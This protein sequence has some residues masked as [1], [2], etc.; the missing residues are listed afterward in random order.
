MLVILVHVFTWWHMNALMK[1]STSH[2]RHSLLPLI[3]SFRRLQIC[4]PELPPCGHGDLI[5]KVN[6]EKISKERVKQKVELEWG[7]CGNSF[8]NKTMVIL[9]EMSGVKRLILWD[10]VTKWYR[11]PTKGVW[12]TCLHLGLICPTLPL[13]HC[14]LPSQSCPFPWCTTTL[15]RIDSTV[16]IVTRDEV[17]QVILGLWPA[18]S[19]N[20]GGPLLLCIC[21]VW[22][23]A[24]VWM[25]LSPPTRGQRTELLSVS[26]G[27]THSSFKHIQI[28]RLCWLKGTF[29]SVWD[30]N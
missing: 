17:L 16:P 1:C 27:H 22:K 5:L 11:I 15:K 30:E 8:G 9:K 26:Y 13:C 10:R 18:S 4:Y 2:G 24:E 29:L 28:N 21:K 12:T 20:G 23:K 14:L 7:Q 3:P 25:S 19:G 6:L